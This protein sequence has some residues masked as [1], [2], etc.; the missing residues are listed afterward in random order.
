MKTHL[1]LI[2]DINSTVIKDNEAAFWWLGQLGYAI[3]LGNTVIYIDAYLVDSPRRTVSALLK[4]N[5]ITNANFVIG[6]HDHSD[7]IDRQNWHDISKASPNA[8]FIVPNP[9][10]DSVAADLDIAR[11]RFYGM[12]DM[13]TLNLDGIRITGIPAAHEQLDTDPKTGDNMY[14]GCVISYK[15]I[16][17]YHSGDTCIYDGLVNKL[18]S[19]GH[20]DLMFIPINGRDGQR[21]RRNCIGNMTYQEAVDLTGTIRP[22]LAVPGHYELIFGN[23]EDVGKYL[24]YLDAKYPDAKAWVGDHGERVII[25]K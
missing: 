9:L 8:K 13:Q 15:N 7:H 24:D 11:D 10:C 21:Y 25:S 18:R 16:N 22:T 20:I 12:R 14:S 1:D 3:K 19:F 23:T 6:T 17:I 2:N 5:E 4:G